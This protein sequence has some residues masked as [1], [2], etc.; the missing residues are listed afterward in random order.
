MK[1]SPK[2]APKQEVKEVKPVAAIPTEKRK[3]SYKEKQE[4]DKLQSEIEALEKQKQEV[5]ELINS[6]SSDHK[7][8]QEWGQK[9]Q[10]IANEIDTKTMRW[11]ELSEIVN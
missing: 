8:L 2:G 9:I 11:L 1:A 4:Y 10:S 5:A 3:A 7:Q 6:G